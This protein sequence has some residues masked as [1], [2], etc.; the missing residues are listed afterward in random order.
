MARAARLLGRLVRWLVYAFAA[1]LILIVAALVA[2]Q[3][4]WAKEQLRQLVVRQA[5]QF[6]TATLDIGRLGG[7]LVRGVELGNVRL[8]RDGEALIEIERVSVS[9]SPRELI[10]AGT[11]IRRIELVRPR[12]VVARQ[13][14]G[15]W[16]LGALI[17]RDAGSQNR[18]GPGRALRLL[19]IEIVD[20]T[21]EIRDPLRFGAAR[22]P[23]LFNDLNVSC[24]FDYKPVAWTLGFA[25]ASWSGSAP[26]L[27]MRKLAGRIANSGTGWMF[28]DLRVESATSRF[29]LNGRIDRSVSPTQLALKVD[30]ERFMFREWSGILPGLSN[31]AIDAEFETQLD[32]PPASLSTHLNLRSNGGNIRGA[33]ILDS[34]AP[35][36]RGSG[37]VDVE[38]L[39]LEHWLNRP[40]RPSDVT[41]HVIFDL[42]DMGF[43]AGGRF[44]QGTYSFDGSHAR[45]LQYEA[46]DLRARG[47]L[48][49]REMTIEEATATAY[50]ASLRVA[51]GAIGIDAPFPFR[52]AGV[53]DDVDL[54]QVPKNAPVPHVESTLTFEYDV[55]G[56]FSTP[57]IKGRARF[58]DSTFVG[59][60]VGAGTVGGIDTS[61]T[62]LRYSGEGDLRGVDLG[63]FG[64]ELGIEW[65]QDPRY[66][67]SVD[68][69][70]HV[71]GTG[72][73]GATMTLDGGGRL[74]RAQLFGGS[75][76]DADVTIAIRDGS[77]EASYDGSLSTI[78]PALALAD[79]RYDASLSGTALARFTV[80]ELLVRP[81]TLSDYEIDAT[82]TLAPLRLR[83]LHADTGRVV[84]TLATST[85]TISEL[86]AAGPAFDVRATGTLELD[87][88]RSSRIDYAVSR[89]DL[90]R[91]EDTIGRKIAGTVTTSGQLTG[92]LDRMQFA[93][94]GTI[95]QLEAG[96][97]KAL[98]TELHY[99]AMVPT[100]TPDQ[101]SGR[102]TGRASF[103]EAAGQPLREVRGTVAYADG[104][105]DADLQ[106]D[107]GRVSGTVTS[108]LLLHREAQLLE[109]LSLDTTI[110]RSSW[111]LAS[112]AAPRIGWNEQGA[113]ITGLVFMDAA[114]GRQRLT[115]DG[116]WY[117]KGGGALRVIGANVSL[118]A[119]TSTGDGPARYGGLA[120]LDIT[121]RGTRDEPIA[122]G[123][124]AIADG[125]IWR[126]A[127]ESLRGRVDFSGG[128]FQLDLRLD[129]RPG[130]W[131]TAAGR[132]P[133]SVLY[134]DRDEEGE[135]DLT[136]R[137]TAI[138]L[139]LLEGAT[140]VV[141]DVSGTLTV[142]VRVMGAIRDPHFDGELA[143][144]DAAFRVAASG[145]RYQR[146]RV[147]LRLER[148]RVRVEMFHLED[149]NGHHLEVRGSLATHELRVSDLAIDVA[150]K[151]F[152]VL[153][154]DYGR[155]DI[156]A[157][158]RL[159]GQFETPRLSG[160]ITVAG[161][162]L[163]V[164][165][166]LD[167]TML[168]PY[169]E[170]PAGPPEVD[171]IRVL[172]P[173]ER[174]GLDIELGVPGTLRMVGDNVQVSPGTPIGLGNINLRAL[175]DLY[176]YKDPGQP[177]YVTGSLDSVRGTYSFQG[178]RFDLDPNSSINFRGD[179]LPE[180]FVIVQ[181]E[182]SGVDTRVTIAGPLDGPE[183]RLTSTPPLDPSDILSLIVFNTA[184]NQL[185]IEQQRDLV[186]RAGALAAGF[187]AAPVMSALERTLG[188]DTLEIEPGVDVSGGAR[189]TIGQEIAPGLVARFSRQFGELEYDEAVLEYYLSKI[190]RLRATFSDAGVARSRFRRTER[191]GIDLLLFFSF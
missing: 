133:L 13:P 124:L 33:F 51:E 94:E 23:T 125:R 191:A 34:T 182:I 55:S 72:S 9:Y 149:G 132:V 157:Q 101:S 83:T 186:V 121:I 117:P 44:P 170:K 63:R 16:N 180:L 29:T 74:T 173:W 86:Q 166:I 76:S 15:R 65:M 119:L 122:T 135:M 185:N 91:L 84:A 59:A 123:H 112:P 93:G 163:A 159:Q 141:G 88:S 98:T 113:V 153:R 118:D 187:L 104:R 35:G 145:V 14:D 54:R 5:N 169:S 156:D 160:R 161:G 150:A 60:A 30:A 82:M 155:M 127:Y 129:Q 172:N 96:G 3:T 2:I 58:M 89:A 164:D 171:A 146:G 152:A 57:F 105:V 97:V 116:T 71:E 108:A 148:D 151:G 110:H 175:G 12:F 137:S 70:F 95:A 4:G 189:V 109:I 111:K 128:A 47:K 138:D 174:L 120:N 102:V 22:V 75:L 81:S 136:V 147:A 181:R 190:L 77:L 40:D 39:R 42:T 115:I 38:R 165:T 68:G 21:I 67:G 79:D 45:Y 103:V 80:R 46:N 85:V 177:L 37:A 7:S 11:V 162:E 32:G 140:D 142:D 99:E 100:R 90:D 1:V 49:P 26:D 179:L 28:D 36:W 20:G 78:N 41:G 48:T 31:I 107:E 8:S 24:T 92:P 10:Q 176:L 154:N 87:G 53:A 73:Q 139:G 143:L 131:L 62:P 130:V 106:L 64:R 50:G 25:S 183:L 167:R 18:R 158:L 69:H 43:R 188:L 114:T 56:R 178:R 134:R 144:A 66:A 168:Q 17:R 61:T 19:E 52:F 126:V 6:L 27:A 184:V